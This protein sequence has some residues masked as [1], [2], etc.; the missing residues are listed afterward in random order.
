VR[1]T[2][3]FATVLVAVT[4]QVLLS[5]FTVADRWVFDLVL[6]GVIYAALQWGAVAG[7][8]AGTIGGLLL[9]GLSGGIVGVGGL[10]KT[11]VGFA[12]GALGSQ[13]VV[14]KAHGRMMIVAAGSLLHRLILVA[15]TAMIDQ[16]WP[17][18]SVTVLVSETLIN[19]LIGFVAFQVTEAMP[20]MVS[21]G[22]LG[23]RSTLIRRNW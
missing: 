19:A 11:I 8:L 20:G 21:R 3:V 9:D 17:P 4:F 10:A 23:R 5:R 14:A 22:R 18:I 16:H 2:S 7:M 15:L 13:L 12:A 1:I 6:V